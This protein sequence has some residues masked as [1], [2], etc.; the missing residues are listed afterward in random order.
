MITISNLS[1]KPK[2]ITLSDGKTIVLNP[3][4]RD[5]RLEDIYAEDSALKKLSDSGKIRILKVAQKEKIPVYKDIPQI[6]D[7]EEGGKK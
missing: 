3:S 2:N 6:K 5:F 4:H 1:G 7:K